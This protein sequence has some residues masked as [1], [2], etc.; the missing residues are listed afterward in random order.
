MD[1]PLAGS[2]YSRATSGRSAPEGRDH[3][4]PG[5]VRRPGHP[6][7]GRTVRVSRIH[8]VYEGK[9]VGEWKELIQRLCK[10]AGVE[11]HFE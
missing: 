10:N 9:G 5:E 3:R 4:T 8:L 11:A 2:L 6:L 7:Y 1:S